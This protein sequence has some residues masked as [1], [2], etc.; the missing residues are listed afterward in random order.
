M[1]VILAARGFL[2]PAILNDIP[3]LLPEYLAVLEVEYI[4]VVFYV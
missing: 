2:T 3:P 4:N 1:L